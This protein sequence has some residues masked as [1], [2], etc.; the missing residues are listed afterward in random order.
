[1]ASSAKRSRAQAERILKLSADR[2]ACVMI[3]HRLALLAIADALF[4][5]DELTGAEV[6]AAVAGVSA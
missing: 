5:R 6:A 2:V 1:M 4:E 3:E